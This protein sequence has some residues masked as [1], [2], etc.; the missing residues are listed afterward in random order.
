M[1]NSARITMRATPRIVRATGWTGVDDTAV[2]QAAIDSGAAEVIVDRQAGPWVLGK[3]AGPQTYAVRLGSNQ[4][5]RLM[6]GVEIV[7]KSGSFTEHRQDS[8][9]ATDGQSNVALIGHGAT[10]RM[11]RNEFP[12]DSEWRC[13]LRVSGTTN[14]RVEGVTVLD[15]PG[16]GIYIGGDLNRNVVV[17]N[18]TCRNNNRNNLT[19]TNVD[20]CLLEDVTLSEANGTRPMCGLDIEPNEGQQI[21][22]VVLRRVKTYRNARGGLYFQLQHLTA[23]SPPV[24]IYC[25]DCESLEDSTDAKGI[26]PS[27][28]MWFANKTPGKGAVIMQR[29]TATDG[30]RG[31]IGI[32]GKPANGPVVE[33][34]DCVCNDALKGEWPI[35]VGSGAGDTVEPSGFVFDNVIVNTPREAI[36]IGFSDGSNSGM[37]CHDING[38]LW[39]GVN[40]EVTPV[41]LTTDVI[42]KWIPEYSGVVGI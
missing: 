10:L 8:L 22:N 18:V 39:L 32:I 34:R 4:M 36:P 26:R 16:D 2:L 6:P 12:A 30:G 27:L 14:V 7:A 42:N 21:T 13:G 40:G 20:G 5:L 38:T 17:R 9:F 3:P 24:S 11:L 28:M 1:P 29:F 37:R 35:V 41:P 23:T 15:C 19:I 25:E 31:S 33:F